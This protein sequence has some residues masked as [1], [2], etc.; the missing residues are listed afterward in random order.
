MFDSLITPAYLHEGRK[1]FFCH[2]LNFSQIFHLGN[3]GKSLHLPQNKHLDIC[4]QCETKKKQ[5]EIG[6]QGQDLPS[7]R[8]FN[9]TT[10]NTPQSRAGV[11][12]CVLSTNLC[13][14]PMDFPPAQDK[15]GLLVADLLQLL[16]LLEGAC[17]ENSQDGLSGLVQHR[18][19]KLGLPTIHLDVFFALWLLTEN[20]DL[21]LS[22]STVMD[23]TASSVKK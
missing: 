18:R 17:V 5:N 15:F 1:P 12:L 21:H 23:R 6:K 13:E 7:W 14:M 3:D 8:A 10:E 9:R 11:S 19:V 2:T 4:K 16:Q 20:G 22:Y